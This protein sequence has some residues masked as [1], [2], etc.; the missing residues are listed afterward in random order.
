VL[1]FFRLVRGLVWLIIL[2]MLELGLLGDGE[3]TATWTSR[4]SEC[5]AMARFMKIWLS[6]FG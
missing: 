1:R 6:F 2:G 4:S 5:V 3:K